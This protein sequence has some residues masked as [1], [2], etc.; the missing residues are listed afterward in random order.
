MLAAITTPTPSFLLSFLKFCKSLVVS[1]VQENGTN[2]VHP[3][4][5][6]IT[7]NSS[8]AVTGDFQL[9]LSASSIDEYH[10]VLNI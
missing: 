9:C 3:S 6:H 10:A 2:G 5:R 4:S 7:G 1:S 8:G